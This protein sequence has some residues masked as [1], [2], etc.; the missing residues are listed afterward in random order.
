MPFK[1]G[2]RLYLCFSLRLFNKRVHCKQGRFWPLF[3][4]CHLTTSICPFLYR[5]IHLLRCLTVVLCCGSPRVHFPK[6]SVSCSHLLPC[7]SFPE[8]DCGLS[9]SPPSVE[10]SLS[11]VLPDLIMSVVRELVASLESHGRQLHSKV[12]HMVRW[13]TRADSNTPREHRNWHKNFGVFHKSQHYEKRLLVMTHV[14]TAC[15]VKK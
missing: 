5:N 13:V 12:G 9:S 11:I 3:D 4:I 10:Q 7:V 14:L 6:V 15:H 8:Q 1:W 2:C